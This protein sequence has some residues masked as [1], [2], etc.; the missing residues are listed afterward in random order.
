MVAIETEKCY[1][2]SISL[3]LEP[4]PLACKGNQ[5]LYRVKINRSDMKELPVAS[6][7]TLRVRAMTY[8]MPFP[9]SKQ[10]SCS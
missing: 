2:T 8:I 5:L 3:P 9:R 6:Y 4:R 10:A 1:G 7:N